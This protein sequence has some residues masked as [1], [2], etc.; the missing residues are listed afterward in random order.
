M[1]TK[2]MLGVTDL[3][4]EGLKN[5]FSIECWGGATFDVA[6]RVLKE[7]PWERLEKL[8]EQIPSALMQML[9][10]G[11][12]ALGYTNYPDNVLSRFIQLSAQSGIDIFRI[13]DALNWIEN[14]KVSIDE[15]LKTDKICEASICYSGDLSSPSEKKYTLDY[16]L[17]MAEKLEKMGVHFLA[18][19]DMAGLCKPK[20]AKVLFKELKKN[21]KIPIQGGLDP[22]VL[23]TNKETIKKETIKYLDIFK[24]HPYIFN[25]GHGV[26]PETDPN[27]FEHMVNTVKNY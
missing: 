11:S 25:L 27:M 8:R 26:L 9:F 23:L 22:K 14:M 16:Y 18:I 10:R 15:V 12:N 2:D 4:E 24:D 17:K 5:L 1:R 7:G 20:A 19:K 21:I 6:L 13:F 3:Y